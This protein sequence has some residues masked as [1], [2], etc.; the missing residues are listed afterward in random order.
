MEN[1]KTII[2][3]DVQDREI[4]K[5]GRFELIKFT[6]PDGTVNA[7]FKDCPFRSRFGD[8]NDLSKSDILKKLT[9]E[10]LPEIEEIVG[11]ENVLEL[12]TDLLSLDGSKKHG[13]MTSKISLPTFD[14]YRANRE[15]F[16]K[17]KLDEWWWLATPDSTSEYYNDNWCV[18]VAPSGSINY[19]YYSN[20]Y[21][22]VRPVLRFVSSISVSCDE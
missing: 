1:A 12:E 11:A 7:V 13:V 21:D 8:N 10:I 17:Y 18:C 15:T 6:M 20:Y 22:G 19:Y 16:E 4:F 14:F 9:S 3:D 5:L 2:L